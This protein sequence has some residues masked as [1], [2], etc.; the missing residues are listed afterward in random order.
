MSNVQEIEN[1]IRRLSP[2][3]LAD[4]REWFA[5]FDAAA[6]DQQLE[7]DVAAGKLDRL[8]EQ[9]IDDFENGRTTDL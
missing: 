2:K 4:L 3:E 9:A 7:R 8:A 1:A 5:E 6:W